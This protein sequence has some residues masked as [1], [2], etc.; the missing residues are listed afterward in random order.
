M[1]LD[2]EEPRRPVIEVPAQDHPDHVWAVC[3]GGAAEQGVDGWA[4]AILLGTLYHVQM[5]PCDQQVMISRRAPIP[6]HKRSMKR[7][8]W[9]SPAAGAVDWPQTRAVNAQLCSAP[10]IVAASVSTSHLAR[11]PWR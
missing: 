8:T 4:E 11:R 9:R 5:S 6:F 3:L 10:R 2:G 7:S 1:A